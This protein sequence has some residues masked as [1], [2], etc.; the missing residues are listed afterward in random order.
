MCHLMKNFCSHTPSSEMV[1]FRILLVHFPHHVLDQLIR[2][3][4]VQQQKHHRRF[5]LR[6]RRTL[7]NNSITKGEE[8]TE[9]G[10]VLILCGGYKLPTVVYC[11]L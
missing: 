8:V 3:F 4:P 10:M 9:E 11:T 1:V 2:G 6:G 5:V 7:Q